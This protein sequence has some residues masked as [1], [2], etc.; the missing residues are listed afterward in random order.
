MIRLSTRVR[1]TPPKFSED[2]FYSFNDDSRIPNATH[3]G[4]DATQAEVWDWVSPMTSTQVGLFFTYGETGSGK[5][6]TVLGPPASVTQ[7]SAAG[8]QAIPETWGVFPRLMM[9]LLNKGLPVVV[10]AVE[11]YCN[12]TFDVSW[13]RRAGRGRRCDSFRA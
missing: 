8:G 7:K 3:F 11:V 2:D 9:E 12:R 13:G 1:G 10:S 6:Y 4:Q 5:T